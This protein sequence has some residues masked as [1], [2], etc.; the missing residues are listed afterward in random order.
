[1]KIG[2]GET[3]LFIGD[4]ITD[5][6]RSRPIGKDTGLGGGYVSLIDSMLVSE[7]PEKNIRVLNLGVNGNRITDLKNRWTRDVLNLEP[8]WLI[9][10]I[11]I[12]DVWR[13]FDRPLDPNQVTSE[14]F[15]KTYS[16]L[17]SDTCSSVSRFVLL[18]PYYIEVNTADPMRKKM[19]EYG[20]I[21]AK[22]AKEFDAVFVD[23][24]GSFDHYLSYRPMESISDDQI[25]LTKVGHMKIATELFR[26]LQPD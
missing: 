22:L 5:C 9:I 1:M 8:D 10:L 4:S 13:Q 7:F 25:H 19:D 16:K 6:S 17:L 15:E 11:G 3:I 21:V 2:S 12:N 23:L 24:Q 18:S 14:L 26:A 20:M